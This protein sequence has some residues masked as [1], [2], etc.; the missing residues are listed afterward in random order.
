MTVVST[1]NATSSTKLYGAKNS[2][3]LTGTKSPA[4]KETKKLSHKMQT[5]SHTAEMASA[6][7]KILTTGVGIQKTAAGSSK[8][9]SDQASKVVKN[10]GSSTAQNSVLAS[11]HPS[12]NSLQS[13]NKNQA[14]LDIH[15]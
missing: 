8:D 14:P 11:F 13:L 12:Q 9:S 1:K 6:T 7:K 10:N 2:A 15:A 5:V 4:K 3:F